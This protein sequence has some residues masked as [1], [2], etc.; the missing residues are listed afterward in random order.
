MVTSE[1]L[2]NKI[3]LTMCDVHNSERVQVVDGDAL[4]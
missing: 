3:Y 1:N 2:D 4:R